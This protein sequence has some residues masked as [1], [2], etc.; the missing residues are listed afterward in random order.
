MCVDYRK[1]QCPRGKYQPEHGGVK[2]HPCPAGS[3]NDATAAVVCSY[4]E[5]GQYS[6]DESVI[7]T[8]AVECEQCSSYFSENTTAHKVQQQCELCVPGQYR[9]KGMCVKC[10]AGRF[11]RAL[12]GTNCTVCP[13]GQYQAKMGASFCEVAEPNSVI[14]IDAKTGAQTTMKCPSAHGISC[15]AG[16]LVYDGNVWHDPAVTTPNCSD[17]AV[18]VCTRIFLCVNNGCPPAGATKME[19]RSGYEGALCAVCSDGY[20]P[21]LGDCTAC[22]EPQWGKAVAALL[23][24]LLVV[25]GLGAGAWKMRH[26]L[27]RMDAFAHIKILVSFVTIVSTLETQFGV[28]WPDELYNLF[29]YFAALSFDL[30]QYAN[31]FCLVRFSFYDTLLSTVLG[32]VAVVALLL[33][34]FKVAITR[35]PDHYYLPRTYA[36]LIVYCLL[37]AYPVVS[38]KLVQAFACHEIDHGESYLKADYS[39]R[40][41]QRQWKEM[42]AFAGFFIVCY[43]VALP[44]FLFWILRHYARLLSSGDGNGALSADRSQPPVSMLEM[45]KEAKEGGPVTSEELL[46]G[47]LLDDYA[48]ESSRAAFYWEAIEMTR[49]LCLSV[50]GAMWTQK[51]PMCIATALLISLAFLHLHLRFFPY[52]SSACNLLQLL[53]QTIICLLYF[54]GLLMMVD[55]V[56]VEAGGSGTQQHVAHLFIVLVVLTFAAAIALIGLEVRVVW[57]AMRKR[58]ALVAE[59][60]REFNVF[61]PE[62]QVHIIDSK[63]LE[64]GKVLGQGAQGVV[65]K[66]KYHQEE[67]AVKVMSMTLAMD[68]TTR[69]ISVGTLTEVQTEAKILQRLRHPNITS[70]F[71]C[72]FLTG[73]FDVKLMVV[74]ELCSASLQDLVYTKAHMSMA[75]KIKLALDVAQGMAFMHN[76]GIIHRDLKLGNVL[77]TD[78]KKG[79]DAY[80]PRGLKA[81]VADF[82]GSKILGEG[83]A[84]A[85]AAAV[86]KEREMTS[87]VGTP[88]YMAPELMADSAATAYS[89]QI[90]LYS[91]GVM[92]WAIIA[93][94]K[95]YSSDEFKRM[96]IWSLRT[97]I[98]EGLRPDLTGVKFPLVTTAPWAVMKLVTECWAAE[99]AQRPGDFHQVCERLGAALKAVEAGTGAG[100]EAPSVSAPEADGAA[101]ATRRYTANPMTIQGAVSENGANANTQAMLEVE[102]GQEQSHVL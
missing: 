66:A 5:Q 69:E 49:K 73:S 37:F 84:A 53:C 3:F 8:A 10:E 7:S 40:C 100:A 95:P 61:D 80:N 88:V 75:L 101:S 22:E 72:S 74:M 79:V 31:V 55:V 85:D 70:Y 52:R 92:L 90:D 81:K 11:Q 62:L 65:R 51:S 27:A 29:R 45:L 91:F 1:Q 35:H 77:L 102:A 28:P 33:L 64:M 32:L 98:L 15:S 9:S 82:G 68:E 97:R 94:A 43:V 60:E 2:C 34:I 50:V 36:V 12:G 39:V 38:T 42:A 16:A 18:P 78:G 58:D 76:H 25:G 24:V 63:E 67:V 93:Q 20:F 41:F 6:L 23:V 99:P 26:A 19:C 57:R 21:Q 48:L 44:L 14:A 30:G 47:F 87:N 13:A 71:G 86:D 83:D 17:A 96:G 54:T 56:P 4:C 59:M 89:K 46:F